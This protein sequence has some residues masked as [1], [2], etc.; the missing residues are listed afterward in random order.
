MTAISCDVVTF[1]KKIE[2]EEGFVL[3]NPSCLLFIFH[4]STPVTGCTMG[5]EVIWKGLISSK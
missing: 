3:G 4:R 1:A 5:Q 2:Y